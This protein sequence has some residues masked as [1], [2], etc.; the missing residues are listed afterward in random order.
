MMGIY[1]QWRISEELGFEYFWKTKLK[2]WQLIKEFWQEAISQYRGGFF[3]GG[4]LMSHRPVGSNAVGCSSRVDAV[5][6][7]L[8]RTSQ[9]WLDA[10]QWA[11]QAPTIVS[12]LLGSTGQWTPSNTWFLGPTGVTSQMNLDPFSRFF[13]TAHDSNQQRDRHTDRPMTTLLRL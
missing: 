1:K 5:I 9:Q 4:K 10:F 6:D 13:C 2:N 11:E 12:S 3:T 8:L 7:F